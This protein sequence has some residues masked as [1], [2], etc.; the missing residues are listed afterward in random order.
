MRLRVGL[1]V[2]L[3]LILTHYASWQAMNSAIVVNY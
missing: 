3:I 2:C 1:S